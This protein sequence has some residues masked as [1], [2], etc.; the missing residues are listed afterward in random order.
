LQLRLR[1]PTMY[2]MDLS[3]LVKNKIG[4]VLSGGG[5]RGA[6]Q[7]GV[8]RAM[9][10]LEIHHLVTAVS[11]TS[12]G[13]LNG[14][15]FLM[16]DPDIWDRTWED[17]T[18]E[19][20]LHGGEKEKSDRRVI[21][22]LNDLRS[23]L[24][25]SMRN[26]KREWDEAESLSDFI[27][28]HSPGL[29]SQDKLE[30]VIDAN[31]DKQRLAR[32]DI[33]YYACAYNIDAM[34]AEYFKVND[35]DP[36]DM[37]RALLAS[38]C[39]PFMYEPVRIG[40]HRYMDGGIHIPLY[41]NQD[42]DNTPVGP[43]IDESCDIVIIVYLSHSER[44]QLPPSTGRRMPRLIEIYPS[45]PLE[46]IKGTG[47]MDFSRASLNDRMELGYHDGMFI[48]APMI[49]K[50]LQGKRIDDLL[51]HHA[52]YNKRLIRKFTKGKE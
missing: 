41:D 52:E 45:M 34:R 46:E 28:D 17:A 8:F 27:L 15:L 16:D 49:V 40:E 20:F 25:T 14:A 7:I 39:I 43:V 33:A 18:F 1:A 37:N 6:Y 11:G 12:I 2:S 3:I 13:A 35:L 44:A 32:S 10:E 31:I 47:S 51:E 50:W 4:L 29:F 22:S 26:L 30:E 48:L 38:S 24:S 21:S 42:I 23:Y 19:N 5:A 9:R 36:E